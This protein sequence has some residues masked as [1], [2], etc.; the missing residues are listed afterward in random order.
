MEKEKHVSRGFGAVTGTKRDRQTDRQRGSKGEAN[1]KVNE[2]APRLGRDSNGQKTEMYQ[3]QIGDGFWLAE[4]NSREPAVGVNAGW[5]TG[6]ESQLDTS[7]YD[8]KTAEKDDT[9]F[10]AS[11]AKRFHPHRKAV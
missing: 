2:G 8:V 7:H 11:S 3:Q 9:Y 10:E 6:K 5:K 4:R 1:W